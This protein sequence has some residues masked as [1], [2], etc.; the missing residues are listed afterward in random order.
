MK[1]CNTCEKTLSF[2]SF[3]KKA[4]AKDYTTSAAYDSD[5]KP[6]NLQ[7]KKKYYKSTGKS[8]KRLSDNLKLY[9][10]SKEEYNQ[11]FTQQ[12]GC[13]K[14]C[15]KHQSEFKKAFSIDH[16]HDTGIVRG[17]LCMHC[18]LILGHAKDSIDTL[19]NLINYLK[20]DN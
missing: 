17:L 1:T 18:N 8:V 12:A 5:C 14:G 13:C 16:C 19:T 11:M 3:Y 9:G 7:K 2:E 15:N 20:G 10:I 4:R 6:C